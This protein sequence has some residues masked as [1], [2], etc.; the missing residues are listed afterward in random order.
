[1]TSSISTFGEWNWT[2]RD[3]RVK[4]LVMY[5]TV[6]TETSLE[7]YASKWPARNLKDWSACYLQLDPL[8]A[9]GNLPYRWDQGYKTANLLRIT[10]NN[11]RIRVLDGA[12]WHDADVDGGTKARILKKAWGIPDVKH[13][14]SYLP[15][16]GDFVLG[17]RETKDNLEIV[18]P[19][20]GLWSRRA[21]VA[22]VAEFR[23][24]GFTRLFGRQRWSSN[25]DDGWTELN[26]PRQSSNGYP[27][28]LW[29]QSVGCGCED[30]KSTEDILS[31]KTCS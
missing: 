3:I 18:A 16:L 19:N 14:M 21:Q 5:S 26:V 11:Q 20:R 23:H 25:D 29:L 4:P 10:V 7:A 12:I 22:V 9:L 1:M 13:L 31:G 15:G 24:E 17:I 30:S 27:I 28:G 2:W 6:G 8:H